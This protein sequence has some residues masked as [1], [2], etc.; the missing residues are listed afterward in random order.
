M[1][2]SIPRALL[3]TVYVLYCAAGVFS[4]VTGRASLLGSVF[5][6]AGIVTLLALVGKAGRWARIT[7]LVLGAIL[8][9]I[10]LAGTIAGIWTVL[11]GD[12]SAIGLLVIGLAL[13]ALGGST[14]VSLR[15]DL[16]A[17]IPTA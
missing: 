3:A 4:V 7:G 15:A 9:L 13:L 11:A 16:K 8:S 5:L 6:A 10:G 1:K 2:L 17:S 12:A 14:L